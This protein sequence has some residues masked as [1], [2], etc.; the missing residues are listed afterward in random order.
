MDLRDAVGER[1]HLSN[2]FRRDGVCQRTVFPD[3][4]PKLIRVPL[5][6]YSIP[7]RLGNSSKSSNPHFILSV[8][9]LTLPC[10]RRYWSDRKALMAREAVALSRKSRGFFS[11]LRSNKIMREMP[12]TY[13]YRPDGSACR[14]YGSIEVKKVTGKNMALPE[15]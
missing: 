11:F 5:R 2:G 15:L 8:V 3:V 1:L 4:Y 14:V 12:P 13:N 6:L 10:P 7:S 9:S